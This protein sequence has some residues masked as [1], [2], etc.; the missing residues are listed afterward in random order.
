MNKKE[1]LEAVLHHKK[2]DMIPWTMYASFPPWGEVER[3][4]RNQGLTLIY[5]HFP[6]V[7]TY[8]HE[9]VEVHEESNYILKGKRG[10][11]II[12]RKFKTPIGQIS[13][14]HEFF[15]D[16]VPL[17][18]D[19][20]QRFG[21]EIEMELLSWVTKHP[22]KNEADY[23]VLEY[24]YKNTEFRPNYQDF[25]FTDKIIGT[26]GYVMANIGKSPFQVLLYELMGAQN[27]YLEFASNNKKAKRLFEVIYEHQKKKVSLASKSPATL[28][29]IPD[30]VTTSLTSPNY[31]EEYYMPFY[32]E[33]A[34]I[35]HREDKILAVHMDGNLKSLVNLIA[36]TRIDIIEAFTP[37]PM[38]DLSVAE[39]KKAWKDKII[40]IN[41]PGTLLATSNSDTIENYTIEMLRSVAPGDN[42][43]IGCTENYPM[44]KWEMAFGGIANAIKKYGKYPINKKK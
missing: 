38:G 24:I 7:K 20:I 12:L 10:R 30:N 25:I 35:L 36:K 15:I 6:I 11:N 3:K 13:A 1:R 2:I 32:N 33:M 42:F 40:W 37:L 26:D 28:I 14:Q 31:F 16:S 5:Q 29:W 9:T 34:D 44:E 4:F 43:I 19:L 23:K 8:L 18:G 21:S 17:P 22:F 27:C 39:A 41:F